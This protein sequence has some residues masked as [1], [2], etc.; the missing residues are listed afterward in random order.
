MLAAV[1]AFAYLVDLISKIIVVE[2][3]EHH[4]PIEVVGTLLRFESVRNAGAAFGM[5]QALT[6][7]FTLI[8]AVVNMIW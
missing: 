8:A 5:G 2:K 4:A 7:V 1:A 3:L 6:V